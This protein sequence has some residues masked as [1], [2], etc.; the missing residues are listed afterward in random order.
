MS[1]L[2]DIT[3][4]KFGLWTVLEKAISSNN[5]TRW[6]CIC[7]CGNV[8]IVDGSNLKL[9]Y[10]TNCGCERLKALIKSTTTHGDTS[11]G[12]S[13]KEYMI[14]KSMIA[15]CNNPNNQNYHRYGGRG[16]TVCERWLTS[17]ENFLSDMGRKP[18]PKHS[19]DRRNNDGNYEPNNCYWATDLEQ[20]RNTSKVKFIEFN[21]KIQTISEWSKELGI[22]TVTIHYRLNKGFAIEDVL[23]TNLLTSLQP[24][25]NIYKRNNKYET[26][27]SYKGITYHIGIYKTYEEACLNRNKFIE[28]LKNK[29]KK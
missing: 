5:S 18:T 8:K 29:D 20:A 10:S 12:K 2:I 11:N 22:K 25:K 24:N 21:N 26:Q 14:Y 27:V 28:D 7:D 15:R 13:S 23:S 4:Q 19:I 17:F 9:G 16:I 6:K 3:G 1:K